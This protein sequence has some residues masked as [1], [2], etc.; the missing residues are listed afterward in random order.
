MVP[1]EEG[2]SYTGQA[3]GELLKLKS[4]DELF[5]FFLCVRLVKL[6]E[7]TSRWEAKPVGLPGW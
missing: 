4:T 1:K 2:I 7:K 5:F 3:S 6:G